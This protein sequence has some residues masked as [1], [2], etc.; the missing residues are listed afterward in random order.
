MNDGRN[1]R[2]RIGDRR[3][4]ERDRPKKPKKHSA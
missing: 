3:L 2:Q 4:R 1:E